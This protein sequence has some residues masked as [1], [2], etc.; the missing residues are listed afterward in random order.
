MNHTAHQMGNR[1]KRYPSTA[2]ANMPQPYSIVTIEPVLSILTAMPTSSASQIH[3]R[4]SRPST[5]ARI[6]GQI[7]SFAFMSTTRLARRAA[8]AE[9]CGNYASYRSN[10]AHWTR[11][12]ADHYARRKRH[13]NCHGA[14]PGRLVA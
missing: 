7:I 2:T 6:A 13:Q 12:S 1:K 8:G 11:Q 10:V 3:L 14:D 5:L 4:I 9:G